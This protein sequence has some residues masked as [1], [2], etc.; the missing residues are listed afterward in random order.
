MRV[1]HPIGRLQPALQE[2]ITLGALLGGQE[3][4]QEPQ[5]PI[6]V[7]SLWLSQNSQ[8]STS[9]RSAADRPPSRPGLG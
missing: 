9:R 4:H 5:V 7:D 3:V 2:G 6:C 8:R 1:Q